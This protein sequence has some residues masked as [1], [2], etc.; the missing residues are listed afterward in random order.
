[1]SLRP[2]DLAI[3]ALY[4]ILVLGLGLSLRKFADSGEEFLWPGAT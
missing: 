3:M 1:M 2:V 4:F